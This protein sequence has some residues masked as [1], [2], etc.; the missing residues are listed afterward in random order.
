MSEILKLLLQVQPEARLGCDPILNHPILL[1]KINI[2]KDKIEESGDDILLQT[3]KVPKNILFLSDRLPQ[4]KY[5]KI[6]KK[7][8][9]RSQEPILPELNNNRASPKRRQNSGYQNSKKRYGSPKPNNLHVVDKN[10][11]LPDIQVRNASPLRV[12]SPK[13]EEAKKAAKLIN[14]EHLNQIY[15]MYV[16]YLKNNNQYKN[17]KYI[18][19]NDKSQHMKNIEKYYDIYNIKPLKKERKMNNK[20][21]SPLNR[22]IY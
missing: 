13:K 11:I 15:Q 7:K 21:L 16:P 10:S 14:N 20:K 9:N 2:F 18:M 19:Q 6:Q 3:I 22:P 17:Y 4:S 8:H 1:K 12:S 5:Q